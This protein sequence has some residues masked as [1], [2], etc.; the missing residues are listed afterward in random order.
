[1]D[2]AASLA[3]GFQIIDVLKGW[4]SIERAYDT[5]GFKAEVNDLTDKV[6]DMTKD[7]QD[8]Q[9]VLT[10]NDK[11]I[12]D[13]IAA[14]KWRGETL[15]YNGMRYRAG[16]SGPQG[17]PFCPRCD[18]NDGMLRSTV[19]KNGNATYCPFCKSE[20]VEAWQF[21]WDNEAIPRVEVPWGRS[22][23]HQQSEP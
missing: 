2:I 19:G 12:R 9:R 11:V 16:K 14:S 10:E 7:L 15:L 20:Y 21:P 22:E 13:L 23:A 4:R 5:V 6:G 8:A 3:S 18:E 17:L 1:M